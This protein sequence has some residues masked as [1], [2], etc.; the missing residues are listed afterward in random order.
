MSFRST[1]PRPRILVLIAA[2][3]LAMTSMLMPFSASAHESRKVATDYVFV[4]GFLDEPAI[5]G[6]TNGISLEVT[7]ADK[8]VTGLDLTLKAEIIV[9][10]QKK[11]VALSPV[12]KTDGSYEAV[13]I[14]TQPGDY[15]FRFFGTVDGTT[16]DETFTS[17]PNGFDSV[18]PRTDYEFPAAK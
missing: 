8:P 4:V 7:K 10:D 11:E 14:P 15:A 18:A 17:S 12:W 5:Q 2:A 13:F 3:M 16:I 6:D 9:G 1:F